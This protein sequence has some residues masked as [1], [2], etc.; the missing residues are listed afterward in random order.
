VTPTS[1]KAPDRKLLASV[2][3]LTGFPVVMFADSSWQDFPDASH[4]TGCYL[5]F[6]QGGL[7]DGASFAPDQV[8]L[9]SAKAEHPIVPLVSPAVNT[10]TKS[11]Q[12]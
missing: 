10:R 6:C 4:S 1:P 9:S 2:G 12:R 5:A 7:V 8:A 3:A 11:F